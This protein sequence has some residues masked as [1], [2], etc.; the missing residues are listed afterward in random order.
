MFPLTEGTCH[1]GY[2]ES[3]AQNTFPLMLWYFCIM[4][5]LLKPQICSES[6]WVKVLGV[7]SP[8]KWL[9]GRVGTTSSQ[10][11]FRGTICDN[12]HKQPH[13]CVSCPFVKVNSANVRCRSKQTADHQRFNWPTLCG[14]DLAQ[15]SSLAKTPSLHSMIQCSSMGKDSILVAAMAMP[16]PISRTR[17]P[18]AR[19][20]Q[21]FESHLYCDDSWKRSAQSLPL[22]GCC[23]YKLTK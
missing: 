14:W 13:V 20:L 12:T 15:F 21:Q 10:R 6:L 16:K 22:R 2:L 4:F 9:S 8:S 18:A 11:P 23:Y 17:P 1:T 5:F 3:G 19:K 7:F